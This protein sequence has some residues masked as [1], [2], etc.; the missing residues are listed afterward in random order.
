MQV[1]YGFDS[2]LSSWQP[3]EDSCVD[4]QSRTC[5]IPGLCAGSK[6]VL[7]ACAHG[8]SGAGGWSQKVAFVA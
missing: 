5:K 1:E 6:Y 2:L 4:A 8:P 7:R 3:V